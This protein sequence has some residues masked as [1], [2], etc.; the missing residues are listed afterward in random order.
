[1]LLP[2][3]T[4]AFRIQFPI[5]SGTTCRVEEVEVGGSAAIALVEGTAGIAV[6][7]TAA[8]V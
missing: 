4:S 6:E 8:A 1:V 3:L 2:S 7:P 5:A